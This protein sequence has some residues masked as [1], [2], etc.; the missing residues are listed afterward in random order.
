MT[1]AI[2]CVVCPVYRPKAQPRLP[3]NPAVCDTCRDRLATDL[4]GLP[5]AYAAVDAEPVRGTTEIRARAFES[6]PPLNI[7]ALSL[8][9]P[10]TVTP[11]AILDFWVQ[12]WA[13]YLE[14]EL[15]VVAVST[16][17]IWLYV[18]LPWACDQHPAIDAFAA[19]LREIAGQLRAFEGRDRGASVGRCPRLIGDERCGTQLYVDPYVDEIQCTRCRQKWKRRDGEWMHLRAQQLSA[20]VEAA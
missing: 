7:T 6:K 4:T 1:E 12:D 13:G 9:G 15:P 20:G 19:D 3:N 2:L 18:R 5:S 16:L 11:L 17:S 10:G 14:Q 8:V